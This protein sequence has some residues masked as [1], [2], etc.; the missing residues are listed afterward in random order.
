LDLEDTF[1]EMLQI[2]IERIKEK[3]IS[4]KEKKERIENLTDKIKF[5]K[6]KMGV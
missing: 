6:S 4:A 5:M 2:G 3:K 1:D